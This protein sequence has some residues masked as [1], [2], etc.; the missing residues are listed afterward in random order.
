V[1]GKDQGRN[2][3]AGGGPQLADG[4]AV[5]AADLGIET[6]KIKRGRRARALSGLVMSERGGAV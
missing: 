4:V 2:K 6:R 1:Q 3:R 5:L